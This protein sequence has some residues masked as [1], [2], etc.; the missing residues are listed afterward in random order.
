MLHNQALKYVVAQLEAQLP[1]DF[2]AQSCPHL[3]KLIWRIFGVI[4]KFLSASL[5]ASVVVA[6]GTPAHA[7]LLT[8]RL[9]A[10]VNFAFAGAESHLV[11][12]ALPLKKN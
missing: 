4:D 5:T 3:L 7:R 11:I 8:T 2:L 6:A 9:R 10:E 1:P 12:A